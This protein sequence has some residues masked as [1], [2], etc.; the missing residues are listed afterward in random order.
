M[1]S[2]WTVVLLEIAL[3]PLYRCA[4]DMLLFYTSVSTRV[5]S[6]MAHWSSIFSIS[7]FLPMLAFPFVK[8]FQNNHLVAFEV[9]A[10]FVCKYWHIILL[11]FK[12][13]VISLIYFS[14][15]NKVNLDFCRG[16]LASGPKICFEKSGPKYHLGWMCGCNFVR[17]ILKNDLYTRQFEPQKVEFLK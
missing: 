8:M 3:S 7:D 1:C 15:K 2:F 4:V 17:Y 10:T 9:I 16:M 5:L 11:N 14:N 13:D 6:C 12:V